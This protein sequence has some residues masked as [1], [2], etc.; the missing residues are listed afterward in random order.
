MVNASIVQRLVRSYSPGTRSNRNISP[1][2]CAVSI[3]ETHTACIS[4]PVRCLLEI[5]R[6]RSLPNFQEEKFISPGNNTPAT[7]IVGTPSMIVERPGATP[8]K[9]VGPPAPPTRRAKDGCHVDSVL[10]VRAQMLLASGSHRDFQNAVRAT[11]NASSPMRPS[12]PPQEKPVEAAARCTSSSNSTHRSAHYPLEWDPRAIPLLCFA[13]SEARRAFVNREHEHRVALGAA[14]HATMVQVFFTCRLEDM[15]RIDEV[16]QRRVIGGLER[17]GRGLLWEAH[18]ELIIAHQLRELDI[19]REE[20]VQYLH[21]HTAAGGSG[22]VQL[23]MA[24][25]SAVAEARRRQLPPASP[26]SRTTTV[27][28][29]TFDHSKPSSSSTTNDE[30]VLGIAYLIT[31]DLSMEERKL[32]L[33]V[34]R[35]EHAIRES[36]VR[37][38]DCSKENAMRLYQSRRHGERCMYYR[39]QRFDFISREMI[40]EHLSAPLFGDWMLLTKTIMAAACG[41]HHRIFLSQRRAEMRCHVA[42][43]NL[44]KLAAQEHW[45]RLHDVGGSEDAEWTFVLR[46]HYIGRLISIIDEEQRVFSRD[47]RPWID[48][49]PTLVALTTQRLLSVMRIQMCY[50]RI[51]HGLAGWR[52]T[53]RR[54][55]AD[56]RLL[57]QHRIRESARAGTQSLLSKLQRLETETAASH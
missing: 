4:P 54:L 46:E 52:A 31:F 24:S 42:A 19:P 50:R 51:R 36:L 11:N 30:W 38:R 22:E 33:D 47:M 26:R 34:L 9:V 25:V 8:S 17:E 27:V 13:E 48:A 45:H 20:V 6:K 10:T 21:R 37:D 23:C 35:E 16:R 53:H 49:A 57:R 5:E 43:D 41:A 28:S 18:E 15:E 3:V 14:I 44:R 7:L 55:G 2:V 40:A 12:K 39:D 32:R 1:C 56:I 29:T